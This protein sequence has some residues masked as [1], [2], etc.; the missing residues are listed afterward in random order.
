MPVGVALPVTNQEGFFEIRLESI[1]GLGANVAGKIL[2]EAGVLHA[3]L[4]GSNFASYGSE[5]KG[6]PVKSFVRF[7]D[8]NKEI[9]NATPVERPHVLGIFHEALVR[10]DRSVL[11]GLYADSIVVLNSRKDPEA[12]RE[13]FGIPARRVGTVRALDIATETGSRT[14]MAMLGAIT[15]ACEFLAPEGVVDA[16]K[17]ALG[18][19]YPQLL[20]ANLEAFWRGYHEVTWSERETGDAAAEQP[21]V[22]P[23]PLFGYET[24]TLGGTLIRPG[25]TW[26]KDMSASRQGTLPEFLRDKC[27][28]CAQCDLV[29]PDYCF[30]W[31]KGQDKRGRPAMVLLGIDYQYCKGCLKC[32]EACPVDAL[33][34]IP[35]ADGWAPEHR[36]QQRFSILATAG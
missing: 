7:A 25:S 26:N 5:K 32:V 31:E 27:I 8:G 34:A 9:R 33:V 4:N 13:E 11:S 12:A 24:A 2:A 18:T 30:V 1:G 19:R 36:V 6:T 29:C 21:Y 14:N 22:R 28:D 20:Q 35:E 17:A 3:G 15:R 23:Q 16:I 10:S